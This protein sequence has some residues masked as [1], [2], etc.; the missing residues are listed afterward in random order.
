MGKNAVI[1]RHLTLRNITISCFDIGQDVEPYLS[2]SKNS[3]VLKSLTF[4]E[5]NITIEGLG[6]ILSV[7][8]A[9]EKLTIGE[10]MNHLSSHE[11]LGR[12]PGKFLK[13]LALQERSLQ[14]IKH[15]GG[16]TNLPFSPTNLSMATFSN[17]REMELDTCS[18]LTR[19]LEETA[20]PWTPTIPPNLHLRLLM[21][22]NQNR[23]D[24]EDD[25]WD[26][27]LQSMIGWIGRVANLDV[28]VEFGYARNMDEVIRNLW[29]SNVGVKLM[30]QILSLLGPGRKKAG[31]D[32]RRLRIFIF[33]GSGY[34]PPYMYGE[35]L[36]TEELL[37]D[38][39]TYGSRVEVSPVKGLEESLAE[40]LEG[41]LEES[42]KES[43]EGHEGS[44]V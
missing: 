29:E 31:Q 1:F 17:M 11:P 38:S 24:D 21:P 41:N 36:P 6:A 25:V 7:P 26:A 3:T 33:R 10:R 37:F 34:I 40:S 27:P 18:I 30:Q 23:F 15:I 14:Y 22:V 9:L 35:E 43:L 19:I 39:D 5:C 32:E 13:A 28:V 16:N 4:D 42:L 2:A 12:Y 20:P 44:G 8:K